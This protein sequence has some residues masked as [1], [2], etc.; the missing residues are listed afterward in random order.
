MEFVFEKMKARASV[1]TYFF[2]AV[3]IPLGLTPLCQANC[4][5]FI[6]F[7]STFARTNPQGLPHPFLVFVVPN[8]AQRLRRNRLLDGPTDDLGYFASVGLDDG[9]IRQTEAVNPHEACQCIST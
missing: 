3:R 2:S 8:T 4:I 1:A 9:A 6:I 7:D 5:S